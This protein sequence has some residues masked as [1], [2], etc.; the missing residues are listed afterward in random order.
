MAKYKF[1]DENLAIID[2]QGHSKKLVNLAD[3]ADYDTSGEM[4][5]RPAV[6]RK[7]FKGEEILTSAIMEV[8]EGKKNM[9]Y[10]VAGKGGPQLDGCL[11]LASITLYMDR[12][13]IKMQPLILMNIDKVPDDAKA[14]LVFRREV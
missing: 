2:Y 8:T 13:N 12:Q 7:S 11:D 1:G 14:V 4:Y 6:L 5:N 3:M 9:V 10:L